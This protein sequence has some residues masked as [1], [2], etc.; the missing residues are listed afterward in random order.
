[1][2]HTVPQ[3][4]YLK[5]MD[6]LDTVM[7]FGTFFYLHCCERKQEEVII[8]GDIKKFMDPEDF[9]EWVRAACPNP[10]IKDKLEDLSDEFIQSSIDRTDVSFSDDL[11]GEIQR[12]VFDANARVYETVLA[13]LMDATEIY[14]S[15][16]FSSTERN[17]A[18]RKKVFKKCIFRNMTFSECTFEECVFLGCSFQNVTIDNSIFSDGCVFHESNFDDCVVQRSDFR[19]VTITESKYTNTT[20]DSVV[21]HNVEV[22]DTV[23]DTCSIADIWHHGLVLSEVTPRQNSVAE[24]DIPVLKLMLS[25]DNEIVVIPSN[26]CGSPQWD[27]LNT[28]VRPALR[29]LDA[30]KVNA[31]DIERILMDEDRYDSESIAKIVSGFMD[32]NQ[33]HDIFTQGIETRNGVVGK[34]GDE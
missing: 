10:E 19:H 15:E 20:I 7:V 1:M 30:S 25:P 33:D 34:D 11:F 17:A 28:A 18:Y 8:M 29:T 22:Y 23:F 3:K 26:S 14:E 12:E 9:R 16:F 13:D 2:G 31:F 32:Q 6:V 24:C 4:Y 5:N 27:V 21:A